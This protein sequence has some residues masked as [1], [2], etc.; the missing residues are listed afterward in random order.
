MGVNFV[1]NSGPLIVLSKLNLLFLLKKLYTKV[2]FPQEVYKETI[3]NGLQKGYPNAKTLSLFLQQNDWNFK[4]VINIPNQI[5]NANLDLGEKEAIA[6]AL[7][8]KAHL[9]ID[10][11]IGRK[12]ANSF[13]LKVKGTLGILVEAYRKDIIN[14]TQLEFYFLQISESKD[15][16]IS[17]KLCKIV[18]EKVLKN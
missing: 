2:E 8:D 6:L 3:V 14:S 12:L 18:L 10:E 5:K 16:W 4:K 9:L 7:E 1:S 13:G 17:P 15:I 11:E